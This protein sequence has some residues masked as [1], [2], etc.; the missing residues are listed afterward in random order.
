MYKNH[1]N[2]AKNRLYI[3]LK[4]KA[5]VPELQAWSDNLLA[6]AKKL[7]AGFGVISDILE[8][9]PTTEDGRQIIQT[10]QKKAKDLGMGHVVRITQGANAITA[11]QWQR[12][13]RAVGYVAGEAGSVEAADKM[14][15]EMEKKGA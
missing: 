6:E 2:L 14:I 3:T 1:A 8:C 9:Q 12:S 10:T 4:G 15:D 5:D 13:S 11:N 7:K